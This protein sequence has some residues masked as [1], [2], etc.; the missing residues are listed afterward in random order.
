MRTADGVVGVRW[1]LGASAQSLSQVRVSIIWTERDRREGRGGNKRC[2][3]RVVKV[4]SQARVS[5][6]SAAWI[7]YSHGFRGE[8]DARRDRSSVLL[9]HDRSLFHNRSVLTQLRLH[10]KPEQ[11]SWPAGQL[12]LAL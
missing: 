12:V 1:E 6:F 9:E 10:S 11:L 8:R 4:Y 2:A 5:I 3:R 7:I